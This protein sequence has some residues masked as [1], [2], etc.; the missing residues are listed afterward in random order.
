MLFIVFQLIQ[1]NAKHLI[2]FIANCR[3]NV[4]RGNRNS[5]KIQKSSI[6]ERIFDR[7]KLSE[8]I[9]LT[10]HLQKKKCFVWY[11]NN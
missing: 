4:I 8:N 2:L 5:S 9:I 3:S 10:P 7:N 1:T 6:Y 11:K